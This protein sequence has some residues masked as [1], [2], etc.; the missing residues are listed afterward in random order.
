M[1]TN[2]HTP[3]P[4][5]IDEVSI[6]REGVLL[7]HELS[8]KAEPNDIWLLEG[9]NGSGKSTLLRA[10]AG[11]FPLQS[12]EVRLGEAALHKHPAFPQC[13]AWV[14]HKRGL[15]LN[16]TV[17]ENVAYWARL[18]GVPENIEVALEYF[19]LADYRSMPCEQLS[20]GWRERVAL[21]RLLTTQ[22]HIWLLDE[23]MAHLDVQ[24]AALVQS[25]L[26]T[27]AEQGGIIFM[28]NHAKIESDRVKRLNLSEHMSNLLVDGE[29][30]EVLC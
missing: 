13:L 30:E 26:I 15:K 11:L 28:S 1:P 3:E 22:A 17:E 20:A 24:A 25:I 29:D 6:A 5:I 8:L 23:P 2:V 18:Q 7:C 16:M 9:A 12:G 19:D 10:V 21:T 14:G 27:R 4:L